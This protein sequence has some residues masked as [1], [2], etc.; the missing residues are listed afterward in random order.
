MSP[1]LPVLSGDDLIKALRKFGYD[2]VRQDGSH[3]RLR[4]SSDPLRQPLTVPRHKT[5]KPGLLRRILRDARI[6]VNELLD[7]L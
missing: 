1:K 5:L 3:V 4:H 2:G 6:S 7:V